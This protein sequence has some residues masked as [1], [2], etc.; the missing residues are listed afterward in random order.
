MSEVNSRLA[1][2]YI[3]KRILDGKF[4]PG[5]KLATGLLST[6]IGISRTP[7]REALLQLETEGLVEIR[8]R[9]GARVKSMTIE[10]F[11]EICELRLALEAHAAFL[12]AE[13]RTELDVAHLARSLAALEKLT[14]DNVNSPPSEAMDVALANE[15]IKFHVAILSAGKNAAI[16]E[17]IFRLHL[18]NRIASDQNGKRPDLGRTDEQLAQRRQV[19]FAEHKRIFEAVRDRRARDARDAMQEHI[20]QIIDNVVM[21]AALATSAPES[22]DIPKDLY[23]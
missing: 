12:A 11:K 15:D 5:L 1:Y 6:E 8:P 21:A 14:V 19:I 9:Q 2:D 23:Y 16:K 17:E 7:V 22:D 18:I 4:Q 20:Q 10:V 3:K 13:N